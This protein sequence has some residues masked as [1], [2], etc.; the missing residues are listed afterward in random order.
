MVK[1]L[2]FRIEDDLTKKDVRQV[3]KSPSSVSWIHERSR[4][5]HLGVGRSRNVGLQVKRGNDR[6]RLVV[7]S[8]STG[9]KGQAHAN[10]PR[11]K[12]KDMRSLG[13]CRVN[14]LRK[15]K[16]HLARIHSDF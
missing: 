5:S 10:P 15:K 13:F 16:N 11:L 6:S 14:S 4:H 2:R 7:H 9:E 1:L 3:L 12:K 8:Q